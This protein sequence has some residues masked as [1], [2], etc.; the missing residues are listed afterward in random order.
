MRPLLRGA[1]GPAGAL[2]AGTPGHEFGKLSPVA[3][4]S[5]FRSA[6]PL[7]ST[8]RRV[9]LADITPTVDCGRRPVK[10]TVG[11]ILPISARIFSDGRPQLRARVRWR[12]H[13]RAQLWSAATL[14]A[15][16]DDL[17][18]GT[19]AFAQIGSGEFLIEA[20]EDQFGTWRS[21]VLR[22]IEVGVDPSPELESG[23]DLLERSLRR[24][25]AARR[26]RLVEEGRRQRQ[27]EVDRQ[28]TFLTGEQLAA[29]LDDAVPSQGISRSQATPVWVERERALHGAW[30]ELFPRSQG[31]DGSH[32][33]TLATTAATLP[34]IAAMGFDVVYLPPIHPIGVTGRRGRNNSPHAGPADPGSPWAIGSKEGGHTAVNPE[35]GSIEDFRHLLAVAES[36]GLEIALDYALQCSPDHPWVTEHPEWFA[37]RPDGTIRPAENPP[38]RYDD[39]YPLDF[40]CRNWKELWEACYQILEYWRAQGVRIFRVDNPHTKPVPFWAWVVQRLRREHPEV[41]LL[42]EAFTRPAM[43][44]ELG[45]LGFSQSYTYFTWRTSKSELTTYLTELARE[46]VDYLRPNLFVNTPDILTEELQRGGPAAFRYRLLLAATLGAS[47]GVYSGFELAEGDAVHPGSEEYLDSEKYQLRPRDFSAPHSLRPL[48]TRVNQIRR[49]HASLR[50]LRRLDFHW[51]DDDFIICYS[52]ST[53]DLD[54][55]ILTVVNLDPWNAR[56]TTIHL[57]LGRLGIEGDR[58]FTVSDLLSGEEYQWQGAH[59]FVR[60]DPARQPGHILEVHR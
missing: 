59:N 60:L 51:S 57:D 29:S 16:Y 27:A 3:N 41:V 45:K 22:R 48:I 28:L 42:A 34:E 21:D 11:E 9:Q 47:Y 24:L 7:P 14:T 37:H 43:M 23:W 58:I 50:Q 30:Y 32:S 25:T 6:P 38:K 56:E 46:T 52:K 1:W 15:G 4:K 53:P 2:L 26:A 5:S 17:W 35:L 10:A 19:I 12:Q 31:T 8:V 54:D 49:Q 20:W 13:G 44:R 18:S 36:L 40:S 33:G 39:I 55:I